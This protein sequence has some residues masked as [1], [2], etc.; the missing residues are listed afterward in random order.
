M[1]V[2]R[3]KPPRS[4]TWW[5]ELGWM[6]GQTV[7]GQL[8]TRVS[9]RGGRVAWAWTRRRKRV[10]GRRREEEAMVMDIGG[11]GFVL[12]GLCERYQG[13]TYRRKDK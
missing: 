3:A 12:F 8:L 11:F 4:R 5:P 13:C 2:G 7:K 10:S 1:R 6:A 9:M